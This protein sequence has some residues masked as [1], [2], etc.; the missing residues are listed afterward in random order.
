MN[1]LQTDFVTTARR[2]ESYS[3]S[4]LRRRAV[5]ASV[6]LTCL[7]A[8]LVLGSLRESRELP[9]ARW[10]DRLQAAE[11]AMLHGDTYSARSLY[12]QTARIASWS[13]DWTGVLA[14]ACGLKK[15]ERPRDNYFATRTTLVRATIAAQNQRS[16]L[17]LNAVANAFASIGEHNA[18]AMVR[19][20]IRIDA[21]EGAAQSPPQR[22][23]CG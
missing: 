16:A 8:L 15:I 7:L 4:G 9:T 12:L 2:Y 18:A 6:P 11:A 23:T 14:A 13:N 19:S 1:S 3:I 10:Q 5:F 17:G 21:P 20:R 22:W